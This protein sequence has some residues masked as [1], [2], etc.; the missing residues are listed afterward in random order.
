MNVRRFF[1]SPSSSFLACIQSGFFISKFI[2]K[3][4]KKNSIWNPWN[5]IES[6]KNKS[7]F[8]LESRKKEKNT[9]SDT[10]TMKT[11]AGAVQQQNK[12]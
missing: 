3:T 2:K 9:Q 7:S 5:W 10:H 4:K 8:Q 12:F 6:R 1:A 11:D